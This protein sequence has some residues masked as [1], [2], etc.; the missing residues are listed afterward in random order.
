MSSAKLI[1]FFSFT[2]LL[3]AMTSGYAQDYKAELI[4]NK[5]E[6]KIGE[7]ILATLSVSF[8]VADEVMFTQ[9]KDTLVKEI[10]VLEQ[11]KID[12]NYTGSNLSTKLLHQTLY[13]TS[14]DTGYHTIPPIWF[15]SSTDS[16]KTDPILIHVIDVPVEMSESATEDNVE[17]KDIKKIID[18]KFSILEWMKENWYWLL[19]ILLTIAAVILYF[20]YL[21]PKLKEN[22]TTFIP[23][24]KAI[25]AHEIALEELSKLKTKKLWQNGKVKAYH[26]QLSEIVRKYIENG[27]GVP[28]LESTTIELMVALRGL[29]YSE[30]AL[31]KLQNSLTLADLV[32]FAK[33]IPLGN[34]NDQCFSDVMAF[35]NHSKPVEAIPTVEKEEVEK[36]GH[37]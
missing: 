26:I 23:K 14:F 36:L 5:E 19:A 27:I 1:S 25:P 17:I 35:I 9:V 12:T 10:E 18:V 28:A 15:Y 11:F 3:S 7:Q 29:D 33:Q 32:K 2:L 30:D 16:V 4:L 34:E 37:V 21:H 8:P 13:L 6:I 22:K 31:D 20:K 24:K